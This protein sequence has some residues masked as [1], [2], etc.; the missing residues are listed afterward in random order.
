MTHSTNIF[1]KKRS[2]KVSTLF[3]QKKINNNKKKTHFYKIKKNELFCKTN[4][5]LATIVEL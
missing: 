3:P 5:T 1:H 4:N 2:K